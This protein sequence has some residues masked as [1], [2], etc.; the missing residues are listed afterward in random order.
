LFVLAVVLSVGGCAERA[1]DRERPTAL[2]PSSR[3]ERLVRGAEDARRVGD[4]V[5]AAGFYE[6][7]HVLAPDRA[8]PLVGLGETAAAAGAPDK[9][10]Q[11]FRQAVII[12]PEDL[13]ARRGYGSVLLT[14]D[15]PAEAERQYRA[16]VEIDPRNPIHHNG[17]AVSLDLQGAHEEAQQVYERG[18]QLS[19]NH[20][21]LQNNK[22]LSLALSGA[23]E[24]AIGMLSRLA[25]APGAS[26]PRIRQNLALVYALA[27]RTNEAFAVTRQDLSEREAR[28]NLA[29]YESL[30][31]LGGR[32][33][34]EAVFHGSVGRAPV[35]AEGSAPA[36]AGEHTQ[37][38]A[39]QTAGPPAGPAGGKLTAGEPEAD[40]IALAYCPTPNG[41]DAVL[42]PPLASPKSGK[43]A[44]G[45]EGDG[46]ERPRTSNAAPGG[47]TPGGDPMP[48]S[49]P[50]AAERLPALDSEQR[51]EG[52]AVSAQ[53][54]ARQVA[55]EPGAHPTDPATAMKFAIPV[56]FEPV[57]LPHGEGLLAGFEPL[58][59][60]PASPT[61]ATPPSP[62][63]IAEARK[64]LPST[65][66][67][68]PDVA[69]GEEAG[70]DETAGTDDL[71]R[72]DAWL[73]N[74]PTAPTEPRTPVDV[75]EARSQQPEG[76]ADATATAAV[77]PP[78]S[79]PAAVQPAAP[80][81]PVS[82]ASML[83]ATI[84]PAEHAEPPRPEPLPKQHGT[85]LL[86][87]ADRPVNQHAKTHRPAQTLFVT[88]MKL[89]P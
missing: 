15:A 66:S 69:G 39:E 11:Y 30:R 62:A 24:E 70:T 61:V 29:L 58:H 14:L 28:N 5:A 79:A 65:A 19:R 18:L 10:A 3:Y 86:A 31:G 73:A 49:P 36:K 53:P 13:A 74:Y 51:A 84:Q 26:N 8:Q 42:P 67:A 46:K 89:I 7:A 23:Y 41:A 85:A 32:A 38:A 71:Q 64:A 77:V 47:G 21:S 81:A 57:P 55:A 20:L 48:A 54:G 37:L 50:T 2:D 87:P 44:N 25:G 59:P 33:L 34:A 40:R 56:G 4:Y 52:P 6:M 75:R 17:L 43:R 72:L 16:A 22:A 83:P 27:G 12:A 9:A 76:P 1:I 82:A 88:L 35:E 60:N 68:S 45:R 78:A 80:P 63:A